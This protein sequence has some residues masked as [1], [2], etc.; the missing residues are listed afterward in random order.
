MSKDPE[1]AM[2]VVDAEENDHED[3]EDEEDEDGETDVAKLKTSLLT[4]PSVM[5]AL[6]G[7]LN[8]MVGANSGY[9][10]VYFFNNSNPGSAM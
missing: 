1:K 3:V 6:Q 2:E 10:E 7:K 4:N 5:A 9:I 8:S